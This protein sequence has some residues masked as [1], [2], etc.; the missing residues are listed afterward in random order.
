MQWGIVTFKYHTNVLCKVTEWFKQTID[1]WH[2]QYHPL[3]LE[4]ILFF[5]VIDF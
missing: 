2:K 1:M 4:N 3:G 5:T